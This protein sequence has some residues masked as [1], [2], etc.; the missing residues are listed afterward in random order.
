[1]VRYIILQGF[2]DSAILDEMTRQKAP[3]TCLFRI[4]F[5]RKR[6]SPPLQ[7][8]NLLWVRRP[9]EQTEILQKFWTDVEH[10]I[11]VQNP[12]ACASELC[13]LALQI[14]FN[15]TEHTPRTEF[16]VAAKE[17][18]AKLAGLF[19]QIFKA[20]SLFQSYNGS[21]ALQDIPEHYSI[22]ELDRS[23][24]HDFYDFMADLME[25]GQN[26]RL[27]TVPSEDADHEV[28]E[29]GVTLDQFQQKVQNFR[30]KL[31]MNLFQRGILPN[32]TNKQRVPS[33][34]L[35]SQHMLRQ[36]PRTSQQ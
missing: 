3:I 10:A 17:T 21:L 30:K 12:S 13:A 4:Q 22:D 34:L 25:R 8:R 5:L 33:L 19:S 7:L 9:A 23:K 20:K 2:T 35:D 14:K 29:Q 1:M 26:L 32:L 11:D 24:V 36:K 6:N 27:K 18:G 28:K 31:E 16:Q 15:V